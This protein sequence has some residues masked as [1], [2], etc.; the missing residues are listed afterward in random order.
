M[1]FLETVS[2]LLGNQVI[3]TIILILVAVAVRY[4][5]ERF[6]VSRSNVE[7][8]QQRRVIS[9]LRN[10]LFFIVLIGL[11]FI[12][13]PA[14]RTFALSLTAFAVAIILATKELILCISG[15]L[16]KTASRSMR[17]GNWIEIN[18]MRGEVVDQTLMSTTIQELGNG[19]GDYSFTGRTIILPNS[20]FL[21]T[22]II[23]E[24]FFKRYVIHSF[25]L[26]AESQDDIAAIEKAMI[27]TINLEMEEH[28]EHAKRY[29]ALIET[30]AGIDIVDLEPQTKLVVTNEGKTKIVITAFLPTKH[31][32]QIEQ[33]AM[34]AGLANLREQKLAQAEA[35]A[36]S[37]QPQP[38]E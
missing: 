22:P 25:H 2:N 13:A 19:S 24:R 36:A 17:V 31:A 37:L 21:S 23:N 27:D 35:Y 14:L 11:M 12:W 10:S 34:R 16:L 3:G 32:L 1:Q 4:L 8:D 30:Q 15:S 29:N 9:N 18:G 28:I 20:I 7:L 5:A 6:F 38:A 33:K 26:V